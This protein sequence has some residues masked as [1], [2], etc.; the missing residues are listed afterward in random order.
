MLNT[1]QKGEKA[2]AAAQ[3]IASDHA[4]GDEI[5]HRGHGNARKPPQLPKWPPGEH[6]DDQHA[7]ANQEKQR[8]ESDETQDQHQPNEP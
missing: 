6:A 7:E 8:T 1:K 4:W 3:A 2:S 5:D